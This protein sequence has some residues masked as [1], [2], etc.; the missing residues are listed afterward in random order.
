[1][2]YL[3]IG[4]YFFFNYISNCLGDSNSVEVFRFNGYNLPLQC[5]GTT[6]SILIQAEMI[7]HEQIFNNIELIIPRLLLFETIYI[8]IVLI[9]VM[10]ADF[11]LNKF[12]I[13][14]NS[15][16]FKYIQLPILNAQEITEDIYRRHNLSELGKSCKD[17]FTKVKLKNNIYHDLGAR[18]NKLDSLTKHIYLKKIKYL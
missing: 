2:K 7:Q 18:N 1:M 13:P 11:Y 10:P 4:E 14:I 6:S 12:K 3:F 9:G 5:S 16:L 8:P 17:Y 15:S